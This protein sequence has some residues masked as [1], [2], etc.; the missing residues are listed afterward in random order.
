MFGGADIAVVVATVLLA[1]C[2]TLRRAERVLAVTSE[3]GQARSLSDDSPA[4]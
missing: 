2:R 3:A 1:P 4:G